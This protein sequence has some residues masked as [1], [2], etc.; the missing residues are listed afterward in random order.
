MV[1]MTVAI[2]NAPG[3]TRVLHF[4]YWERHASSLTTDIACTLANLSEST[5]F[6][7]RKIVPEIIA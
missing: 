2:N 1:M 4:N 3:H 7:I 5:P 6:Y